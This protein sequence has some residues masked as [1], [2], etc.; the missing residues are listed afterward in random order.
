MYFTFLFI[1]FPTIYL[2]KIYQKH[3]T[4][5]NIRILYTSILNFLPQLKLHHILLFSSRRYFY[6]VDFSPINQTEMKT[7]TKLF[8]GENVPAEIRIRSIKNTQQTD[9]DL[10]LQW[11]H[12]NENLTYLESETL[13]EKTFHQIYDQNIKEK[14]KQ[15]RNYPKIMNLYHQNCQHFSHS[16][17]Q[18]DS[19]SDNN[20][21]TCS[22]CPFE[23][24]ADVL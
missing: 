23:L 17:V 24:N 22:L 7:L 6:T 18:L 8:L 11:N 9:N 19:D 13:T 16:V 10:I 15:I 12:L 2:S 4:P 20:V 14:I 1:L 21:M 5:E 3:S